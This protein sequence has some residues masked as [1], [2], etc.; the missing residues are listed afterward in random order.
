[1]FVEENL[2]NDEEVEIIF[3]FPEETPVQKISNFFLNYAL[4]ADNII[5]MNEDL[6]ENDLFF[7]LSGYIKFSKDLQ[8]GIKDLKEECSSNQ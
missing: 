8:R 5:F 1:M 2:I 6:P 3:P 7:T 4:S